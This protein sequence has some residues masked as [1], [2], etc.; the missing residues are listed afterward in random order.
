MDEAVAYIA[1]DSIE[2]AQ[3][4]LTNVLGAAASLVTLG[5]RGR[6]VPE[7]E[8]PNIRELIVGSRRLIY[9]VAEE[10]VTMLALIHGARDLQR[11]RQRGELT[12]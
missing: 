1:R 2:A 7:L 3:R 4:L 5:E 12:I 8:D 9:S 11:V 10:N 6:I